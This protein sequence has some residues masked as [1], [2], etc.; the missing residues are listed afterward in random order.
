MAAT[1]HLHLEG[2]EQLRKKCLGPPKI[3]H[4]P[5]QNMLRKVGKIAS[6]ALKA[7][8]TSLTGQLR[9]SIRPK[10]RLSSLFI[11]VEFNPIGSQDRSGKFRSGW[12][13]DASSKFTP[14]S[15]GMTTGWVKGVPPIVWP[16]VTSGMAQVA[17]EVEGLWR[18]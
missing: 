17:R 10:A 15:G 12:A 4:R 13:F 14:R 16:E 1:V 7:R 6:D 8:A 2:W 9:R 5:T 11:G 18:A 3:Y